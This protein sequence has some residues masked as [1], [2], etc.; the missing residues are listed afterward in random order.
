MKVDETHDLRLASPAD[1]ELL[2]R[3]TDQ[4]RLPILLCIPYLTS[5]VILASV[6]I[7]PFSYMHC[8][9]VDRTY[10]LFVFFSSFSYAVW[11]AYIP[12]IT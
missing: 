2:Q 4:N 5:Y 9:L 6:A 8:T 10:I 3:D 12:G 1:V 7:S 11:A